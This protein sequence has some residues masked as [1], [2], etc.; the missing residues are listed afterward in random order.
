M[1]ERYKLTTYTSAKISVEDEKPRDDGTIRVQV[2]ISNQIMG[3][4]DL[5][6]AI[7]FLLEEADRMS[8]GKLPIQESPTQEAKPAE[9]IRRKLEV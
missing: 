4:G 3:Q 7:D 1:A 9:P 8:K 6:E 5:R 2:N